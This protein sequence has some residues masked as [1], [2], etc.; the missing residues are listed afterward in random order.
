MLH[1]F[2][3][4]TPFNLKHWNSSSQRSVIT[5]VSLLRQLEVHAATPSARVQQLWAHQNTPIVLSCNMYRSVCC[6]HEKASSY[7]RCISRFLKRGVR[8]RWSESAFGITCLQGTY[9][10]SWIGSY[11]IYFLSIYYV[12]FTNAMENSGRSSTNITEV[13]VLQA[14][15]EDLRPHPCHPL[16]IRPVVLLPPHLPLLSPVSSDLI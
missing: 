8:C 1:G 16:I 7:W 4:I 9:S 6:R 5:V 13:V 10:D 15:S 12:V 11:S 14:T 2:L 3:F